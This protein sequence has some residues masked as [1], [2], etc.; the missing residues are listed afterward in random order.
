MTRLRRGHRL[1]RGLLSAQAWCGC[2]LVHCSRGRHPGG[3]RALPIRSCP[4]I[5]WNFAA[6]SS[7]VSTT[8]ENLA[9][10]PRLGS[11]RRRRGLRATNRASASAL[12]SNGS[13][14]AK[15]QTTS[16]TSTGTRSTVRPAAWTRP[17]R[18]LPTGSTRAA[19]ASGAC[20]IFTAARG[21]G[22]RARGAAARTARRSRFAVALEKMALS[23]GAAHMPAR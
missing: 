4:A 19:R 10:S 16:L 8:R 13:G 15:G 14:P 23:S 11:L 18:W 7:T 2:P 3:C 5:R 22:R 9:R 20:A 1:L 17:M 21:R 12:S 6:S